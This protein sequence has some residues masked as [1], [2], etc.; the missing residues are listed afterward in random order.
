V[1]TKPLLCL[2]TNRLRLAQTVGRPAAEASALLLQQVRGAV[3]GGVDLVQ[4]RESDLDAGELVRLVREAVG[5]ARGS[6]TRIVVND[7][8]D[9]AIAA[10]AAGVHLRESSLPAVAVRR[11][12]P[13]LLVGRS[14]H[15]VEATVNAGPV[16]YLIAGTVFATPSKPGRADL[17]GLVGLG[18]IVKAARATPVLAI[19]GV[20]AE[21]AGGIRAVG[22]AG[23]AAIHALGPSPGIAE[24]AAAVEK[25]AHT[26][27][28][29]FDTDAAVP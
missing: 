18:A 19:G 5:I 22:A 25:S 1:T 17:I 20:N 3:A 28:F 2:V 14:V 9:V 16:D 24:L 27:R 23:V 13:Q 8:V 6:D 26:L 21:T 29:A 15:S 10:G 4:I 7:R 11:L 12:A